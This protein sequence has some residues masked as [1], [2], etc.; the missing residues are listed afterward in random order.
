MKKQILNSVANLIISAV[1]TFSFASN[2]AVYNANIL[3]NRVI[4]C[5]NLTPD[6]YAR[7][8]D[9]VFN[10]LGT[11]NG[12]NLVKVSSNFG[13]GPQGG[14][15]RTYKLSTEGELTVQ[16]NGLDDRRSDNYNV[17]L[18][19]DEKV[20]SLK[21]FQEKNNVIVRQKYDRGMRT[22]QCVLK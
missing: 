7:T 20:L 14:E 19:F 1:A 5:R 13:Y 8:P 17:S 3:K 22:R 15:L 6:P 18:I 11:Q 4:V 21:E 12:W 16:V 10:F 2:G 9:V